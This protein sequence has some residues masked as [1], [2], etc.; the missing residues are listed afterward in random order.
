VNQIRMTNWFNALYGAEFVDERHCHTV[1]NIV[2]VVQ[3]ASQ[4]A[5]W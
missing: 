5:Y 3:F 2:S 1:L 4:V